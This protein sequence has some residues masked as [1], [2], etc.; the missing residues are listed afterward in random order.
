MK[1]VVLSN[2]KRICFLR[3]LF[4]KSHFVNETV[5]IVNSVHTGP[6]VQVYSWF[7]KK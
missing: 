4:E 2:L 7:K 3:M 1:T 6:R 5:A